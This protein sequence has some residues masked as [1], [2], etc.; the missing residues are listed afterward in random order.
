MPTGKNWM[1]FIYVNIGFT[2][3]T[4]ATYYLSSIKEIK[5][6][7]PLYRCNPMYMPLSDN[8][9]QDFTYCIQNIT[10]SLMGFLLQPL[11]FITSTL[12][13]LGG[14]FSEQIN[15]IRQMFD[16]IR[17]FI[18]SIIQS[19]F[20]VFLNIIIEFQKIIMGLKDLIG[21]TIGIMVTLMYVMDGSLKTMNS[22]WSG[23]TGQLVK[24]LG[25]CF[26]PETKIKLKNGNIIAIKDINLGDILENGSIVHSTMKIDNKNNKEDLY[27]IKE[28]GVNGDNIYVTGSH[29]V[30]DDSKR[31]FVKVSKYS[32]AIKSKI[33]TEWF[34][35]LITSDHK[36]KIGSEIFWDWE[37]HFIK[38]SD[39]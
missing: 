21:K 29:L 22:A 24:A 17:T 7:W 10:T 32:K 33:Q 11:T 23:P 30:F 31:N 27:C 2:L 26:Y 6:N 9:S 38:T 3:Y 1:Y 34:S 39:F 12:A 15:S 35:C 36:I 20:G 19:I 14:K 37:D 8:M 4:V 16:K 18:S 25:K 13:T 5:D 28:K